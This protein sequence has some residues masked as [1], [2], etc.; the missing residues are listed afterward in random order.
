MLAAV[1]SL[2]APAAFGDESLL[3]AAMQGDVPALQSFLAANADVNYARADGSTALSW[4]VYGNQ[5]RAVE[6]LIRSGAD[7]NAAN[8]YGVT[9][10]SLACANGNSAVVQKLLEAGADPNHARET[11]E[12]PLMTCAAAGAVEAVEAL[13]RAGAGVNAQELEEGQT[14]LMWAAARRHSQVIRELI[15]HGA[16]VHARSR[17]IPEPEP[18]LIAMPENETVLGT[19]YPPTVRFPELTGGFTALHFAAQQGDVDSARLLLQAGADVN[20][21]HPEHGSP[22][23]IAIASGHEQ[24]AMFL[25]EQGADPNIRDAWGVGPLHYAVHRGVLI[26]NNFMPSETDRFGWDR[27]TMPGLVQALLDHGAD[28]N[29]RITHAYAFLDNYFLGRAMSDPSQID[30]VGAT[31]LLVAAAA[32]D[33]E[34]MRI[35]EEVSDVKATTIGGATLFML[36]SGAGAERK[37]RSED[38]ALAAARFALA[39]GGGS[40]NDRLTDIAPDGP[41]E[42]KED[43]RTPLHFAVTQG[44]EKMIRFLAEQGAD[45]NAADRYGMTPMQLAWGDPEGRY[46]RQ[47]GPHGDYDYRYRRPGAEGKGNKK[48]VDLLLKLGAAPFTGEFRDRS[49]E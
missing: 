22:L 33:L 43:G 32:G 28:P 40:V 9:P 23:V 38:E 26:L 29:A 17:E 34:S 36:A 24:L 18:Y 27:P 10:L 1:L 12:T 14:A 31:P 35:L 13:L 25:L 47:I 48:L 4:A 49:G 37:S 42:G 11:G 21:P 19:N 20:S 8:D 41:A 30:P 2:S 5:P 15:A 6:L 44:W 3:Q 7:V 39:V 16:D 46:N 45:L